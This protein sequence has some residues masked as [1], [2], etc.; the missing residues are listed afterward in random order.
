V[1]A[2]ATDRV[3]Q[4]RRDFDA[5]FARPPAP[6][7]PP[8]EPLLRVS[9]GGTGL[10]VR[11]REL[12]LVLPCAVVVPV[13]GARRGLLGLTAVRGQILPLYSLAA[14][15]EI[16]G[17]VVP[18]RW[19]L[20]AAGGT[21]AGIGVEAVEGVSRIPV[22]VVGE[23]SALGEGRRRGNLPDAAGSRALLD[24]TSVVNN[25]RRG[26]QPEQKER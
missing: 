14:L 7:P 10:F 16:P 12:A 21:A 9:A 1:S 2:I 23:A 3:G 18:A 24:V 26:Q 13:P 4:M 6:E 25:L 15:L 19:I 5:A 20:V 11:I 22:A 17:P 8:S